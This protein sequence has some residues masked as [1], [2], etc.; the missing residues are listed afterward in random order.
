MNVVRVMPNLER[1]LYDSAFLSL[2]LEAQF[3]ECTISG[4]AALSLKKNSFDSQ[5]CARSTL[6]PLFM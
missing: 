4:L 3:Q 2:I 1:I 5:D 6:F